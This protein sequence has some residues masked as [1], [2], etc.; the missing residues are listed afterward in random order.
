MDNRSEQMYGISRFDSD[1]HKTRGWRVSLRRR[2]V[3]I[4]ENF[5][6]KK[7]GGRQAALAAAKKRRDELLKENPPLT[8]QEFA[9][10]KR[11]HNRTGI[12]G[13]Y[14]YAKRYQLKDGT[15]RLAWYW[16]ANWP[17]D[18]GQSKKAS[19]AVN[20]YGEELA[21]ELAIEARENGMREVNG[22][23]WASERGGT[24]PSAA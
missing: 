5:A 15:I 4:V 2:G 7:H 20:A 23:Y 3:R 16:E 19:F 21:R 12:T 22:L 1:V 13:V 24:E 8:R 6:D 10:I 17:T 14:R 9:S 18:R 11:R